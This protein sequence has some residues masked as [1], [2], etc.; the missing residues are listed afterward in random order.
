MLADRQGAER[1]ESLIN[2]RRAG[3]GH[4]RLLPASAGAAPSTIASSWDGAGNVAGKLKLMGFE[5]GEV[6]SAKKT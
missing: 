1:R 2:H 3:G 4:V 5:G 6:I